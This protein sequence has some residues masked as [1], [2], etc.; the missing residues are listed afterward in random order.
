MEHVYLER[1]RVKAVLPS[2]GKQQVLKEKIN[3]LLQN[4]LGT[5]SE[6]SKES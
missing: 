3:Y 2:Q 1:E 6:A 4:T 5:S